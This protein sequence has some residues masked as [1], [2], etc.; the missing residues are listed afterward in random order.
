MFDSLLSWENLLLAFR[1][2]ARGK[3]RQPA[4]AAFEHRLEDHLVSLRRE[5]TGRSYRPGTYKSFYIHEPKRRLIS[6]APFRDRVVHHALVNVIEPLFERSF[7]SDSYANR[8]GKG[9]HRALDRCQELARRYGFV[10]QLDLRQ[11]FPSID[12][13]VLRGILVE[14]IGD[15][16]VLW[17]A[18][19]ILSSGE[20]VLSEA[21]DMVY[22]PGDD[23]FAINRPRGLPIGNLTSQFWGN[24]Y[25]DSLD[26]FIQRELRCPGYVRYVDDLLL[27]SDAKGELWRAG[28]VLKIRLDRLRITSHQGAHPR[29]VREGIPFLGFV[30]YP[31][32]RRLKRRKKVQ[33]ERQWR[34]VSTAF[35]HGELPGERLCATW[36][37]W[38]NHARYGATAGLRRA[39][40]E[41][42]PREVLE[43]LRARH[44]ITVP[45][46]PSSAPKGTAA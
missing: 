43:T 15:S 1:N 26:H 45:A 36:A 38:A 35:L 20:G 22:F 8:K 24:V 33:F 11:F 30:V 21:Y 42:A 18:D 39:L 16:S 12:H 37:G 19:Q 9:T 41:R 44:R 7:S 28:E 13:A 34:N 32:H 14:R 4:V 46:L 31:D 25:L 17:L 29:P 23:L 2:A 5:L 3:R 10:L 27:F 40:L 6:A